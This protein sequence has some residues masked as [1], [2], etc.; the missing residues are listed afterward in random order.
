MSTV[1]PVEQPSDELIRPRE[2]A[3]LDRRDLLALP[4][5]TAAVMLVYWVVLAIPYAYLDDYFWLEVSVSHPTVVYDDQAVQGRPLNGYIMPAVF[6]RAHGLSGLW[7]VRALT[8]AGIGGMGWMFYLALRRAE[9]D[10]RQAGLL[11][12]LACVVPAMQVYAAWATSVAN[13]LSGILACAAALVCGWALDDPR[14]RRPG[15]VAAVAMVLGSATIY[16]PTAMVFWPVA[17]IDLFRRHRGRNLLPRFAAYFIVAMIGLGLAFGV[18]KYGLSHHPER[19]S[20][21]RSGVTHDPTGKIS[22]FFQHPLVDSLNLFNMIRPVPI[23]AAIVAAFILI[24]FWRGSSGTTGRKGIALAVAA[25]LFPLAYLPNLAAQ[26]SWSSYRSQIGME[27][28][29]LVLVWLALRGL[30]GA[31]AVHRTLLVVAVIATALVTFQVGCLFAFPQAMEMRALKA[32]L[33]RPEVAAAK[34]IILLQ[35]GGTSAFS[36]LSYSRYD[37]FN[38]TSLQRDWVPQS[39]VNL[40]RRQEDPRLPRIPVELRGNFVGP[41]TEPLPPGTVVVDM[42]FVARP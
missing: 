38:R 36:P 4:A 37:E 14:R 42:R 15:F 10:Q 27:W 41:W 25:V 1:S 19:P 21:E 31:R 26:E 39:E 22:W 8:L 23:P 18:F 32:Q 9:C 3:G 40:I 11:A 29:A 20:V 13:P 24:G 34:H 30:L 12:L 2:T 28:V 5:L 16:Q 35:P 6:R 7:R 17:A 33:D